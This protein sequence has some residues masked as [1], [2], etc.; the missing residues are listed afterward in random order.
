MEY[1][2][3]EDDFRRVETNDLTALAPGD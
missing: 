3:A 1:P 2:Q